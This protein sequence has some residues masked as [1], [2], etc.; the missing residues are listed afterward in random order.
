MQAL[1]RKIK[2]W[3]P[4][5]ARHQL[6]GI[7]YPAENGSVQVATGEEAFG[8]LADHWVPTCQARDHDPV[9]LQEFVA[10]SPHL[11]K[12]DLSKAV[13]P[14]KNLIRLVIR[15][16]KG[17]KTKTG[18]D[19]LPYAA[20]HAG[21]EAAVETIYQALCACFSGRPLSV[22]EYVIVTVFIPKLIEQELSG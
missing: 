3:L 1:A 15:K 13:V 21:G 22:E 17:K 2:L 20:W 18:K 10:N 5:D 4:F 6:V 9:A 7:S 19:G 8:K 16:A 12:W 11:A 14:D